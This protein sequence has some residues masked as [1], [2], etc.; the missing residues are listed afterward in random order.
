MTVTLIQAIHTETTR[1]FARTIPDHTNHVSFRP[2]GPE[3]A[4]L[5]V[6]SCN[7]DQDGKPTSATV[8]SAILM[9]PEAKELHAAIGEWIKSQS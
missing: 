8:S 1:Y 4:T 9:L 7:T 3:R 6:R 5:Q 2:S